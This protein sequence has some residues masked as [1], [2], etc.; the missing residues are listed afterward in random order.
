[1]KVLEPSRAQ[2]RKVK[3]KIKTCQFCDPENLQAQSVKSLEG[4]HWLV[5]A[6]KYPYLD[7]NLMLV[8]K[9]HVCQVEDLNDQEKAEFF[10]IFAKSKKALADLFATESFNFG[11]N[12]GKFSG[13]SIAHLHWQLIP[14]RKYTQNC[15]NIIHD[16]HVIT[17]DYQELIDKLKTEK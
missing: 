8:P 1:M 10:T 7:G 2:Y 3:D 15:T 14:R 17:M 9:R 5:I 6:N 16:L 4:E 11:I 13:C 12:V